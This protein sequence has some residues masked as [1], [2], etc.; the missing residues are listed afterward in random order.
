[1]TRWRLEYPPPR[2]GGLLRVSRWIWDVLY[3]RLIDLAQD[4][5][6]NAD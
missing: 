4:S 3:C 1:M 5:L 6:R 2:D